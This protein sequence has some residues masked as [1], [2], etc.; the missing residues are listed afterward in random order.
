MKPSAELSLPLRPR[1][2]SGRV[3][4]LR[5]KLSDPLKLS[6]TR[7]AATRCLALIAFATFFQATGCVTSSKHKDVV[8]ERDALATNVA[9][10]SQRAGKL[11]VS[12]TSLEAERVQIYDELEDLRV[13][14]ETLSAGR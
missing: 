1:P 14:Q 5:L 13:E 8:A 3:E 7:G 2:V 6:T 10:L 4:L 11:E 12:N 9:E